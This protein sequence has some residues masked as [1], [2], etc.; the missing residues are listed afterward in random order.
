MALDIVKARALQPP[1]GL[2][3]KIRAVKAAVA[4]P[5]IGQDTGTQK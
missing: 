3:F 4:N 1:E 2:C 5:V